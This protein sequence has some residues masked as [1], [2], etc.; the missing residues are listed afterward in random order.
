MRNLQACLVVALAACG[1]S[2][3]SKQIDASVAIDAKAI[4]AKVFLDAPTPDAPNYDFTCFGQQNPTTAANPISAAGTTETLNSQF[5]Q[6]P[7]G[8]VTVEACPASSFTCPASGTGARLATTTSDATQGTFT[9]STVATGGT[10]LDAYI[11]AAKTGERTS[12]VYPPN[13]ITADIAMIPVLMLSN[14]QLAT[15]GLV[16]GASPN[17]A[18]A[19]VVIVPVDCQNNPV[20]GAT[21][22]V[23]QGSTEVGTQYSLMGA[24][25]VTDVPPDSAANGTTITVTYGSM[26]FPVRTVTAFG[27]SD[28]STTVRPGP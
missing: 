9:L 21:V 27:A 6:T 22:S 23:K 7:V 15:L 14:A 16:L 10:P 2:S 5:Q 12:Y 28:I 11:K 8:G 18:D 24:T 3:G 25:I 13:A 17:A 19:I 26:T 1:S 4:D 20:M